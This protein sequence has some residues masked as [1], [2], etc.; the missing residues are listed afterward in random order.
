MERVVDET[1]Q[2]GVVV[3]VLDLLP[4]HVVALDLLWV[5]ALLPDLVG[6]LGLMIELCCAE[7]TQQRFRSPTFQEIDDLPGGVGLEALHHG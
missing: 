4:H 1:S 6:T 7:L 3:D 5:A 2:N